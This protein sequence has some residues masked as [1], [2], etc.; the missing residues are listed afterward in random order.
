MATEYI[1]S[2][3][4]LLSTFVSNF[5]TLISA[6]PGAYG[7]MASDATVIAT[8]VNLFNAALTLALNPATKTK[9]TVADK[10]A[11]KA[12]ML[13]TV[14]QYSQVIKRNLGVSNDAKIGLGLT[15][16]SGGPSPIPAPTTQPVLSIATAGS[17]RQVVHFADTTAPDR[18]AKPAGVKGLMLA[19]AVGTTPPASRELVPTYGMATKQSFAVDFN[20]G[21]AAKTAYYYGRW[22]TAAGLLGPWSAL[23][24]SIIA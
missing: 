5:S 20:D 13:V 23:A 9:A 8:A 16:N 15:I 24:Q 22:I 7:L 6:T 1:P 14:R 4:S 12:A 18:R 17:L 10:N 19:V 2:R 21:D 3:E 11:K